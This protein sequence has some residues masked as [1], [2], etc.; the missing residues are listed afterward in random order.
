MSW[1]LE[2]FLELWNSEDNHR[3]WSGQIGKPGETWL[4]PILWSVWFQHSKHLRGKR[5]KTP[6]EKNWSGTSSLIKTLAPWK[7]SYDKPRQYIKK[8]RH[9]FANKGL[10]SQ[11]YGFSSR[12]VWMW[13]LD[14]KESW[15]LKNWCFWTMVLERT[16][17]SLLDSKEIQPV[18][19]KGNQSWIFTG[20]TGA[21]AE[22]PILWPPDSKNWLL[23]KD[24]DAGRDW[25]QEENGKLVIG[26]LSSVF[27]IV[28]GTV[29]FHCLRW[30]VPISLK[31]VLKTVTAYVMDWSL[32]CCSLWSQRDAT[33][34][35]NINVMAT[36]GRHGGNCFHPMGL[37]A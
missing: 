15:V 23:G 19:P 17:E 34:R 26:G 3:S 8:L 31:P 27:L 24:P 36:V 28:L 10:S 20:R 6:C 25:G 32:V 5:T 16:L 18:H 35:L 2:I 14:H 4:W 13:E 30:F 21:E 9:H 29:S 12:H 22:T 7:K 1:I 11:S 33:E 37:S